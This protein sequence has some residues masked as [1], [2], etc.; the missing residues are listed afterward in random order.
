MLFDLLEQIGHLHI[1]VAVVGVLHL[2]ALAED[3]VA[4]VEEQDAVGLF[5]LGEHRLKIFLRL[6]DILADDLGDIDLY[7]SI[8]SSLAMT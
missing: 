3:G 6:A 8:F 4:L 2:A 5:G 1:G 7:I